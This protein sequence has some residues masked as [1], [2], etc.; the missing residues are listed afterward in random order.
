MSNIDEVKL[1]PALL[2][3]SAATESKP[4]SHHGKYTKR[5]PGKHSAAHNN[6][7]SNPLPGLLNTFK[8]PILAS[9]PDNGIVDT[10]FV[11]FNASYVKMDS[12]TPLPRPSGDKFTT[13]PPTLNVVDILSQTAKS[14]SPV[15]KT[16]KPPDTALT[17][18]RT[19]T[20]LMDQYSLHNFMIW[21]GDALKDTPEF[22]S[23]QRTYASEWSYISVV[24]TKLENLMRESGIKLAIISGL[25]LAELALLN[26]PTY[27]PSDLLEVCANG[28]QIKPQVTGFHKGGKDHMLLATIKIQTIVRRWRAVHKFNTLRRKLNAS[29]VMQSVI[30]KFIVRCATLK[31]LQHIKAHMDFKWTQN[32]VRM[33]NVWSS[34]SKRRLLIHIPSI[35]AI[36]FERLNIPNVKSIENSHISCLHQ[37][38]DSNV[39][40][41]Y[42]SPKV[43]SASDIAYIDKFLTLLNI[44]NAPRRVKFIVPEMATVLPAHIPLAHML[45]YSSSTLRKLKTI[46]RDHPE[47]IIIASDPGWAEKRI[48]DFLNVAMA[49]PDPLVASD[50]SLRSQSKRLFM[51][52]KVNIPIG[53]HDIYNEEDL[54][55]ALSRL[56]SSNLDIKRWI[57]RLNLDFNNQS[58]AYVDVDNLPIIATLKG[59]Q[60]S[61]IHT[62]RDPK[63]W[64]EKT[65]QLNARKRIVK[66][67]QNA[68]MSMIHICRPDVFHNWEFYLNFVKQV[69]CVIEAEPLALR[70]RLES[71]MFIDP[72][73][74][75]HVMRGTFAVC[76]NNYQVQSKIYPQTVVHDNSLEGATRAIGS[77]LFNRY[78]TIGYVTVSFLAY[79]DSYD[80]IP[81]LWATGLHFGMD[82]TF[83]ALG[84]M[85]I[86]VRSTDI[87]NRMKHPLLPLI[88]EGK[89]LHTIYI[90]IL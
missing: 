84:T 34:Q 49:S 15:K 56:M 51:D 29:V 66:E 17:E 16:V 18:L 41:I 79:Y 4:Q 47:T 80:D 71:Y 72:T 88:P 30:R 43:M 87:V 77:V 2:L 55:I 27:H 40:L 5:K 60:T 70:G 37:L 83:G 57:I 26:L 19:Y 28:D 33:Q 38:I 90:T 9:R 89:Y 65:I 78:G 75:L 82:S 7:A 3:P 42:I 53:A 11:G 58:C 63:T 22:Q 54:I 12:S 74:D 46:I 21:N 61:L 67:F 23:F 85:A 48:A 8:T 20:S 31:R 24:I 25:K 14:T 32:V 10:T 45:W 36:E 64:F 13:V 69:G 44:S 73:G 86:L 39:E 50:I 35:S 52:A 68:N 6:S 81:R 76:D 62:S 1:F 59:E